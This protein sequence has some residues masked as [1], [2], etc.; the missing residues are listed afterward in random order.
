MAYFRETCLPVCREAHDKG[1]SLSA[2]STQGKVQEDVS[3][4]TSVPANTHSS[5]HAQT[6]TH[7]TNTHNYLMVVLNQPIE[8]LFLVIVCFSNDCPTPILPK[9]TQEATN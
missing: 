3:A 6:H 1:G 5:T 2:R 9:A 4:E 7:I 8:A